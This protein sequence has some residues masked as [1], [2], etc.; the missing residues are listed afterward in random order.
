[1]SIFRDAAWPHFGSE[2]MRSPRPETNGTLTPAEVNPLLN[3]W[4]LRE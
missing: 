4:H 2:P 1:M 3:K